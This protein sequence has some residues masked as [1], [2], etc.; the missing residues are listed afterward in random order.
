[1]KVTRVNLKYSYYKKIQLCNMMEVLTN[2]IVMIILKYIHVS[3]HQILYLKVTQCYI[4]IIS[5]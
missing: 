1:M 2:L 3:N 5:Q 4:L